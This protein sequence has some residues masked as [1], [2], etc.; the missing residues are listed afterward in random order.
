MI[1]G[2]ILKMAIIIIGEKIPGKISKN[3]FT[4]NSEI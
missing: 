4:E 1:S 3:D 2:K